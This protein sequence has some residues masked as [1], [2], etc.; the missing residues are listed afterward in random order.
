VAK[1]RDD[2]VLIA[3]TTGISSESR[4]GSEGEMASLETSGIK[5]SS[6]IIGVFFVL[7]YTLEKIFFSNQ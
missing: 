7:Y 3:S 5:S 6:F 2:P 1:E 4:T